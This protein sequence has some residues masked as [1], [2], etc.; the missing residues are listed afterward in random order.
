M[1][2]I[3]R[4]FILSS[5]LLVNAC[6]PNYRPGDGWGEQEYDRRLSKEILA[7]DASIAYAS[8]IVRHEEI[9]FIAGLWGDG[10]REYQLLQDSWAKC[11]EIFNP[12][13]VDSLTDDWNSYNYLCEM[14][15]DKCN[16]DS[17]NSS[18]TG[19][20][21]GLKGDT[22]QVYGTINPASIYNTE[23]TREGLSD[24][25]PVGQVFGDVSNLKGDISGLKGDLSGISGTINN[26]SGFITNFTL[27]RVKYYNDPSILTS[28]FHERPKAIT[29]DVT[30]IH[31]NVAGL[32][33]DVSNLRGDISEISG[34][35]T[36]IKGDVTNIYGFCDG[37]ILDLNQLSPLPDECKDRHGMYHLYCLYDYVI[38][39]I[40]QHVEEEVD[41]IPQYELFW[42]TIWSKLTTEQVQAATEMATQI[43]PE[44]YRK[45]VD[46]ITEETHGKDFIDNIKSDTTKEH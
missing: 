31:G 2:V 1:E 6:Y 5:L 32:T 45:L 17:G 36:G 35:V 39:N 19:A 37:L 13:T 9:S 10:E 11:Q 42:D 12:S 7:N 34:N 27:E 23:Y 41:S 33:G 8:C 20:V 38:Q 16:K 4:L 40:N 43:Q 44:N 26:L 46:V 15:G 28:G 29:G 3:M 25:V 18:L 30:N 22:S 24:Y 14:A 21:S